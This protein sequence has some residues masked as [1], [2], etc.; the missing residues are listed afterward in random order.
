MTTEAAFDTTSP[1]EGETPLDFFTRVQDTS[2]AALAAAVQELRSPL[3]EGATLSQE[4][5]LRAQK[6]KI[7]VRVHAMAACSTERLKLLCYFGVFTSAM[8]DDYQKSADGVMG[9]R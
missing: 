2:L 1:R 6:A 3:P 5:A 7:H 4:K 8:C 9:V